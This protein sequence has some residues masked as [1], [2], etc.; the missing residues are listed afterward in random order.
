MVPRQGGCERH[1]ARPLGLRGAQAGRARGRRVLPVA[2]VTHDGL[3]GHAHHAAARRLLSRAQRRPGRVGAGARALTLLD[4]H[5]PQLAA[6]APVPLHRP[7]RRDQH[8]E[9]QS[10]LDASAGGA[11]RLR[12]HPRRSGPD[13]PDLHA[14]RLRHRHVRRSA[15]AAPPRRSL[16]ASRGPDDDSRGVGEPREHVAAE[17][18]VLPVPRV[19]DGALGRP[20]LD[21]VHRWNGDGRGARPQ[22]PPSEPVLGDARWARH[23]GERGRGARRPL[24]RRDQQ[25]S[26]RAREDVPRRHHARSH[27]RRRGDQGRPRRGGAVPRLARRG[28]HPPRRPARPRRAHPGARRRRCSSSGCSVGPR[29]RSA[30]S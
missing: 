22:R 28:T 19:V 2:L 3:Q 7:Q 21:R 25:G 14:R 24:R 11:A 4:Q 18:G 1:R 27:R 6:R 12:P 20:R 5:V 23:H 26:A 29:R 30:Y 9:G 15:R 8:G 13:L 17:A 10:Q 16:A